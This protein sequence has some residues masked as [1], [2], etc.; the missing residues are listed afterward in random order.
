[1]SLD[2]KMFIFYVNVERRPN[3]ECGVCKYYCI[4]LNISVADSQEV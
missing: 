4:P 3:P 2:E 1:M